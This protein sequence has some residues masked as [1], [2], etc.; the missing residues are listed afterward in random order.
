M[1]LVLLAA[2][3][4]GWIMDEARIQRNSVAAIESAGGSVTYDWEIVDGQHVPS[5][6]PPWPKFLWLADWSARKA[7]RLTVVCA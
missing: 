1:V 7:C 2:G 6:A 5:E 3:W 4:L